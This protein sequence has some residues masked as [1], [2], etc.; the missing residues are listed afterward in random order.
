MIGAAVFA[1]AFAVAFLAL[2]LFADPRALW[3]RFRARHFEH[4]EAHEPSAASFTGRRVLL[5]ALA[6]FLGWQAVGMLRLAGVFETEP[7]HAEVLERVRSV[8]RSVDGTTRSPLPAR[9]DGSWS[10]YLDPQLRGPEKNDPTAVLA[11]RSGAP[12]PDGNVERYDVS[13]AEGTVC[14]TV[15]ATPAAE[16]PVPAYMTPIWFDLRAEAA[17]GACARW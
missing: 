12:E 9:D 10:T 2:A 4:P 17:D 14:L 8:A 1:G 3:W 6:V 5:G 11:W 13:G 15:T 16:Q 7:E